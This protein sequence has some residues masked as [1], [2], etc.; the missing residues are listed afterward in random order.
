MYAIARINEYEIPDVYFWQVCRGKGILILYWQNVH[1]SALL[2]AILANSNQN[3]K[4][5]YFFVKAIHAYGN[6]QNNNGSVYA[7]NL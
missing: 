7:E 2:K 4:Y 3:I 6:L 5:L 1:C